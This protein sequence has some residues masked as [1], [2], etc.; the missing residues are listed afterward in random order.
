VASRCLGGLEEDLQTDF[1]ISLHKTTD[2]LE[3]Q[4]LCTRGIGRVASK[5]ITPRLIA[6]WKE[7]NLSA[8]VL[9]AD[10]LIAIWAPKY[11]E[12]RAFCPP[13]QAS[14]EQ[15]K[16]WTAEVRK[17]VMET[18]QLGQPSDDKDNMIATV[19]LEI[20]WED[21]M[22]AAGRL[23]LEEA[24]PILKNAKDHGHVPRGAL[25]G[26]VV[27]GTERSIEA[28]VEL[29]RAESGYEL[30]EVIESLGKTKSPIAAPRLRELLADT[31]KSN[32][33]NER[34]ICDQATV[35]L[36]EIFPDGP[37]TNFYT[38]SYDNMNALKLDANVAKWRDYLDKKYPANK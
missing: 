9:V 29:T 18:L 31:S 14:D 17:A 33:A 30:C 2:N 10:A 27:M 16:V 25:E 24:I 21:L 11:P 12:S 34:R 4:E 35:V 23:K 36:K 38:S 13:S 32:C 19:S 15:Q 22:S 26:L 3:I 1:L 20:E 7:G 6:L 8:K 28:L 37:E 5:D